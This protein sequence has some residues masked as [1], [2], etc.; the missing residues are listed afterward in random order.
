[1]NS[2]TCVIFATA[3]FSLNLFG[4]TVA[5]SLV[6]TVVDPADAVVANAPVT[7]V[8]QDTAGTRAASTD[9]T[10]TFR[11]L[12]LTPGTYSVTVKAPGFKSMTQTDIVVAA[13]ETRSA[14]KMV[15]QIGS[16]T[17]S[18]SVTA[19]ATEV[20]LASSEKAQ[21]V[22]GNQL[23]DVTLKGRDLFGYLR[24]VPGV[25]D[26]TASRDVTGPNQIGGITI[27]GNTSAKNFTV[28]GITDMD[29]GSNTTLH[30][31]P[32]IDSIQELKIL[33]SN[34]QAE[35]G[36]NSGGTI[37]VVTKNGTQEFHGTGMWNHR[38]EEF[39][40]NSWANNHNVV[41]GA[42]TPIVPYR[43]NVETYSIG[44][45]A[46]IPHHVNPNKTR[47][48]FF[49]SQEYTGQYVSGG[50]Q[51][52]YTPTALER[53]GNF[54]QS[55]NNNG[56]QIKVT[57]PLNNNAQFSGNIVPASRLTPV[58]QAM[59]A[60]FPLPN[61]TPTL[62]AQ[63]NVVNY[64]EQ[65]SATHPRRNDVVRL[66]GVI[67]KK[68]SGYFRYI[69]DHDDMLEL[70]QGVS[71][72]SD[73]G[74]TLGPK[75]IAPIDHPNPGHS[76]SGSATYTISPTLINEVT[77]G[78]SWNTWSY[79]STD[80]YVSEDRGLVP[81]V[82]SL[83]PV[84]TGIVPGYSAVNSYQ[85]L[86]PTFSFGSPPSNSMAYS[87][88]SN[89]AGAF[90]NF[91]PIWTY[92]DNLSKV[93]G[94]HTFK[95][96]MYLEHNDKLE[97]FGENYMGAFNFGPSSSNLVN[98]TGDGY[99]N[100]ILGYV[101][102][103]SQT[104]AVTEYDTVYWNAEFYVQD[105][106]KVNRRLTLDLG[107]RFY[108]QTPQV[109]LHKTFDNFIPAD[110]SKSAIPRI[111]IAGCNNGAT[112][113]S[114]AARQAEDPLTKTFAPV[115]YIGLFV[116]NTG[117]PS[118]GMVQL[119]ANG[120]PLNA[121]S[122]APIAAAP[123]IGF[124]YDV[125]GDGKTAIRGGFGIFYNR[126]DGNQVYNLSGQPPTVFTPTISY[127]TFGQMAE[128]S[129]NLVV[130]PCTC[131]S[132]SG[133]G[134]YPWEPVKNASIDIQRSLGASVIDIGYTGNFSTKQNLTYDIN[135]VPV[136][137]RA[138]FTPS[139]ADPTNGSG[140]YASDI[141]LRTIYPGYGAIKS[142]AFLGYSN[143]N[144]L[145][146][147]MQRRL[148]HG[149]AWGLAY[150]YSKGMGV[151]TYTPV[152][153]N[154]D[155]W[156]YGRLSSDRTHNLQINY[157]YDLPN[158]GKAM[159]SKILGIFTD[160]WSL[161]GITS[162]QSGAP[163]LPSFSFTSGTAPDYTGTP[164]VSARISIVGNP[165]SNVPNGLYFNPSAF[166]LP[167][168]G[169]ASPATPVL[170]NAGGGAG[171]L[172]LPHKT[173][174]DMTLSKAIPLGSEKRTL[175]LQAQ[176]YN[177]FNHTEYSGLNTG[178]QF[179]PTTGAVGNLSSIAIPSAALANRVMALSVRVQF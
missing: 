155:A 26:T 148:T 71:F 123:R 104:S 42:A 135:Y 39:N 38:H 95:M 158:A 137:A 93:V 118:S 128:A 173:N 15:L 99:A 50:S 143:Y 23:N 172:S 117:N 47:L 28:D 33:T 177:V 59:L 53:T 167:A 145:T 107:V 4:Q 36:R 35:F 96:G 124:A 126:L 43:Y 13:E 64:F 165:Y 91:N 121:Y 139:A 52:K 105:N 174:F 98:N 68:L 19:E 152:V 41:N 110:Y 84:P 74:G 134:N 169:T 34:Y 79:Y 21:T 90:E 14:G 109:D 140:T 31:E 130:G 1:M 112:T 10:G 61:F 3:I 63:L 85:N 100:G 16:V 131:N 57:D 178:I 66:D 81:G 171:V 92:L 120:V 87:R 154:N 82:P 56:T 58:G 166:S 29:T 18:V 170:G 17:D 162:V 122:F 157:N 8:N 94:P 25:I 12:N 89:T 32:N 60:F 73:V 51:S 46:Y 125:F 55:F 113:C 141:F 119:G 102:S 5:S 142:H 127:T 160:H 30:Y 175:R 80:N 151:T 49:A 45:P 164:D 150:T 149:F 116:P 88:N 144:A 24:L 176:A 9:S 114:G 44:G 75:G 62:P 179:N 54:S 27:N 2:K 70:Y 20:Q 67:T 72:T 129:N 133:T 76:Y 163:F 65:G 22:D 40:A 101:A 156:N 159:N 115:A 6:G 83:F 86:L 136:G 97:P 11:F 146:V 138:P 7:L 77:V 37:T 111:Y 103:Y 69:N 132:W 106:W 161:S 147:S 153:A 168:L 78:E 48:F 108:H